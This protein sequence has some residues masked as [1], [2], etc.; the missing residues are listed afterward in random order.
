M[1]LM[2]REEYAA[3]NQGKNSEK[4]REWLA[5]FDRV[6]ISRNRLHLVMHHAWWDLAKALYHAS[7]GVDDAV[8]FLAECQVLAPGF[9]QIVFRPGKG[10]AAPSSPAKKAARVAHPETTEA[11]GGE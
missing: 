5:E 1:T 9:D 2:N 7:Y 6:A 3:V 10:T 8:Q 11:K 4:L